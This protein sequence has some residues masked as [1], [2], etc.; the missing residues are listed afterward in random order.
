MDV[1][2]K[3]S[4]FARFAALAAS[5]AAGFYIVNVGSLYFRQADHVYHP[6]RAMTASPADA[7]LAYDEVSFRTK[8]GVALNA[9]WVP[10]AAE[11]RG[12]VL[13]F[14]GNAGNLSIQ[15]DVVRMFRRFG[16]NTLAVDYRGYGKSEGS[17]SEEGTYADARAAWDWL[18]AAKGLRA[19]DVVVWGR[20]LGAGVATDLAVQTSEPPRALVTEAAFTSL[21]DIAEELHPGVPVRW[22]MRYRYE[23]LKKFSKLRCPVLVVHSREDQLISLKHGKRLYE[24]APEP[25]RF[26]EIKGPHNGLPWQPGY[27]EGLTAFLESVR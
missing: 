17:P 25:K 6:E 9:W 7:G 14:H 24:A 26:L 1:L 18:R 10:S 3:S 2:K 16:Y 4:T 15:V 21:P 11:P 5:A 12:T 8:D 23:N 20:S 13:Y 22:F 27:E 19:R